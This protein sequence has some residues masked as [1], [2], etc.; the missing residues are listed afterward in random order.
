[1][2]LQYEPSSEPRTSRQLGERIS[3]YPADFN[4]HKGLAR[5]MANKKKMST[6]TPKPETRNSQLETRNPKP[7]TQNPKPET[8]NLKPETHNP[9]PE[10][11]N[12]KS[13]TRDPKPE[14]PH[15]QPRTLNPEAGSR[16]ARASTGPPPRFSIHSTPDILSLKTLS[17]TPT[18]DETPMRDAPL[19]LAG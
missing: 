18:L 1:M 14:T 17:F 13:E 2:S 7:D 6:L 15:P 19:G 11:R 3:S 5:V 12:P 4:I 10:T 16:R 8:R 9:K